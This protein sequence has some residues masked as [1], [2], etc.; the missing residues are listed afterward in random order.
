M[1]QK[2]IYDYKPIHRVSFTA[3][4]LAHHAM[5]SCVAADNATV[6]LRVEL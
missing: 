5:Q 2:A 6:T 4:K 3:I 1:H